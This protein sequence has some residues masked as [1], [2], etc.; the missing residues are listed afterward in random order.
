MN[1]ETMY[2]HFKID[3]NEMKKIV[4][5]TE[6]V[7]IGKSSHAPVIITTVLYDKDKDK[8]VDREVKDAE[9]V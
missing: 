3:S 1:Y 7:M 5:L 8:L 9:L 6:Q 2:K 4:D